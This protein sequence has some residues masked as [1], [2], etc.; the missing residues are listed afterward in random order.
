M[1]LAA[2]VQLGT[3]V[4]H[5]W[6]FLDETHAQ[7]IAI[8]GFQYV[9]LDEATDKH[10]L[11]MMIVQKMYECDYPLVLKQYERCIRSI[12]RLDYPNKWP[13]LLTHD[14]PNLL[15]TDGEKA[16]Y[17]G[18]LALLG[19]VQ[20]YEYELEDDRVPLYAVLDKCFGI[21][22]H[23]INKLMQHTESEIALKILHLICKV[24]YTSNQLV[25]APFL[26]DVPSQAIAPWMQ[27]FNQLLKL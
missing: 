12:A 25:L 13:T 4:E 3:I 19:L 10:Q 18:L 17:T 9:I 14:I 26:C 5:H 7:K 15:Q 8:T 22:G 21:L 11:R 24:F 16:V 23:L 2:A 1:A 6:K 20:K 27:F